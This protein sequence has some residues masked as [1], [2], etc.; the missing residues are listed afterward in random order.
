MN[1]EKKT[2]A[3]KSLITKLMKSYISIKCDLIKKLVQSVVEH[4]LL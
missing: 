1:F 3:Q 2:I 4:D